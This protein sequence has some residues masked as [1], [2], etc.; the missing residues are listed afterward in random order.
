VGL[1]SS[2]LFKVL[3]VRP[4]LGR[5]FTVAEDSPG[6]EE[7]AIL[8]HALWQRRYG[9][10]RNVVGRSLIL[11]GKPRTIVGVMPA[12]F[13]FPAE[14]QL[15]VPLAYGPD[16]EPRNFGFLNVV[17][18]LRAGVSLATAR[19]EMAALG[20]RLAREQESDKNRGLLVKTLRERLVGSARPALLMLLGVTTLVFLIACANLVNLLLGRQLARDHEN[21]IRAALGANRRQVMQHPLAEGLLLGLA[22]GVAGLLLGAG[23]VRLVARYGPQRVPRLAEAG[24]AGQVLLAT[25]AVALLAGGLSALL[26]ALRAVRLDLG[27]RL[28]AT[29]RG[30]GGG[31]AGTNLRRAL[32]VVEI[33]FTLLLMIGAGLLLKSLAGLQ[34]V[35]P[36]FDPA[37]V[38]TL[39]IELPEARYR[40][41]HQPAIFYAELYR[42]LAALPGVQAAG[43]I[44][45]LPLTGMNASTG[46]K[47]EGER[48]P[49]KDEPKQVASLRPVGPDYFRALGMRLIRGRTFTAGDDHRQRPVVVINETLARRFWPGRD[50]IGRR[51]IFG[52]DFGTTGAFA[53]EPREIVGIVG[54][55]RHS[56]LDK[57][58]SPALYVPQ[59]QTSW[60]AMTLVIRSSTP[61]KLLV[62]AVRRAVWS[63][64]PDLPLSEIKPMG[65]WVAESLGQTRFYTASV[66]GVAALAL[67]L[68][69]VGLYGVVAYSVGARMR[70]I[71]IRI[72]LGAGRAQIL[73]SVIRE[74]LLLLLTG[75]ILGLAAAPFF[76]RLLASLLFGVTATDPRIF[77]GA[78]LVLAAVALAA[79]YIPARRATRLA[80]LVVLEGPHP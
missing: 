7:V 59:L 11:D 21:T 73:G 35:D 60:R 13:D 41:E 42:R 69:M 50:P 40:E 25:L 34:R 8:S 29:S 2:S 54:D 38:L 44:F 58:P 48:E 80:P 15:W 9:G 6:G 14:I 39:Q 51:M 77:Y 19:A 17:G 12:G 47:R 1:V 4:V 79:S 63:L 16:S 64:D 27:Q 68:A 53:K 62:P 10:A 37:N 76:T 65:Q 56:G 52:V 28:N 22:G 30:L 46:F 5:T 31:I 74:A 18:R 70:E 24:I 66:A 67:V 49:G 26:P 3:G 75:T 20:Q 72:A 23:A 61:P 43:G 71:G 33:A 55:D 57:D 32:V 45:L 36:G 78:A